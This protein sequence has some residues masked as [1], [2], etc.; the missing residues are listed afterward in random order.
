MTDMILSLTSAVSVVVACLIPF[1]CLDFQLVY[2]NEY[3]WTVG[4]S[5]VLR[6]I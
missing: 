3:Q 6:I 4:Q 1:L 2:L 5:Q